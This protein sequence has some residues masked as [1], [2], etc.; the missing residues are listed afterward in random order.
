MTEKMEQNDVP[1]QP[2]G[3]V[4]QG[5]VFCSG[6]GNA[7]VPSSTS[8]PGCGTPRVTPI[9]AATSSAPVITAAY[10]VAPVGRPLVKSKTTSVVL[11]VFLG[12]WSWLYTYKTDAW[13]FWVGLPVYILGLA[14]T[15]FGIGFVLTFGVQIWAIIDAAVKSRYYFESYWVPK[16]PT[17]I[18]VNQT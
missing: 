3:G 17:A 18:Y 9:P 10:Y 5:A 4:S 2:A 11:A 14:L 13:K 7:L 15:P 6:C 16:V 12:Y 1:M 8:C